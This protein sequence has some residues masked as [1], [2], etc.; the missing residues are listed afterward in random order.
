MRNKIF[1]LAGTVLLLLACSCTSVKRFK[2]A[3]YKGKD[4]A[5]VDVELFSSRLDTEPLAREEMYLWDLSANAQTRLVQILDGRFPDNGQFMRAL[6]KNYREEGETVLDDFTRK[7]L[8]M[9]FTVSR[10]RE[11]PLIN[12]PAGRFSPADRIEYLKLSLQ[13]PE[14]NRLRFTQWNHFA[15]EYGEMEIADVSFSRNLELDAGGEP[16]GVELGGRASL[17]RSEKQVIETRYLKLNGSLSD[18]RIVL[19]EEGTREM[20]LSGNISANISLEFAAFPER[21]V[22]P[23]FSDSGALVVQFRDVLVPALELAPDTLFAWLSLEYIYRHVQSGW[24]TFAEWDDQVEYYTGKVHK[25]VPL[26]TKRDYIPGF[27]CIGLDQEY[28]EVLKYGDDGKDYLLQF[29]D[30]RSASQ[31]MEWLSWPLRDPEGPVYIGGSRVSFK[32]QAFT[33]NLIEEK[34]LKVI[35][36]YR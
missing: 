24:H 9:V 10:D 18:Y 27:Y 13:I 12:D 32:G 20:D 8:H 28:R 7:D 17:S 14:E 4:D 26:F 1:F 11:Y 16:G 22:V 3:D 30:Y 19:E 5:L 31:F 25:Q 29:L 6:S 23:F 33:P 15:T 35:P 21:V 2:S 36:V 34:G